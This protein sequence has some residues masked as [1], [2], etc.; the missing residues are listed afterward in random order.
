MYCFSNC[1]VKIIP[2]KE[3]LGFF[4]KI[5][6]RFKEWIIKSLLSNKKA[7][8]YTIERA[9]TENI[10]L[11]SKDEYFHHL[12]IFPLKYEVRNKELDK[13]SKHYIPRLTILIKYE[14]K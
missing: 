12:D 2:N 14:I 5:K 3:N 9:I 6:L 1:K 4:Q 11:E 7:E 10:H 8:G 13:K